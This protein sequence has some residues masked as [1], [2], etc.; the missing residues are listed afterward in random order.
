MKHH[1]K[2]LLAA[3]GSIRAVPHRIRYAVAAALL[4]RQQAFSLASERLARMP[5][6]LGL[7][8]RAAFYRHCLKGL[9]DNTHLGFMTLLSK[10]DISIARHV[11]IGRFCT[12]GL[13]DIHEHAMIADGAQLLSGRH[14]HGR[15]ASAEH[16]LRDNPHHFTRITIGRGAWIGAN[17]VIMANVGE[18]AVVA[19]GAV[20]VH[21]VAPGAR[22]AGVPARPI[23]PRAADAA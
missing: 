6:L 1:L 23:H 10:P 18:N 5:G 21:P 3:L 11:Y 15:A 17:A 12:L 9:G 22:V 13:C 7:H 8:T 20:V 16:T 4:G 19:A 2:Q 14:Q